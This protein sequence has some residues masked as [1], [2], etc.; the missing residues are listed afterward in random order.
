[1]SQFTHKVHE[2]TLKNIKVK[3]YKTLESLSYEEI[4]FPE[5]SKQFW[6]PNS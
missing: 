5:E 1:M 4:S 2:W 6:Y 3:F